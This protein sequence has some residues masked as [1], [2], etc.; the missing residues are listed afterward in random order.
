MIFDRKTER[1]KDKTSLKN[2]SQNNNM[3]LC[4]FCLKKRATMCVF[5][6][7]EIVCAKWLYVEGCRSRRCISHPSGIATFHA[8]GSGGTLLNFLQHRRNR[9]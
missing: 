3:S 1:Q 8:V 6:V 5:I 9:Q 4:L 2:I 7:C